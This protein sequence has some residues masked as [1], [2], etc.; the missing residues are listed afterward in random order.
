MATCPVAQRQLA[1]LKQ[2]GTLTACVNAL[3]S[4]AAAN[5]DDNAAAA[6]TKKKKAA[7]KKQKAK[8]KPSPKQKT[9]TDAAPFGAFTALV[10]ME[11]AA[12]TSTPDA[13]RLAAAETENERRMLAL[14]AEAGLSS[15]VFKRAPSD[16]YSWT[17]EQR[18]DFLGLASIHYLCKTV[19]M[20]NT[21]YADQTPDEQTTNS[22]YYSMII[23][24]SSKGEKKHMNNT[25]HAIASAEATRLGVTAPG[26]KKFNM[27]LCPE[28]DSFRLS[29]FAHNGVTPLGMATH[30]PIIVSAPLAELPLGE[31]WLGAGEVDLKVGFNLDQFVS[32]FKP[33]VAKLT[34]HVKDEVDKP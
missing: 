19:I 18:R 34:M 29:G 16:Y 15:A 32:H 22:Q 28:D 11:L 20:I 7:A 5:G 27:R 14:A 30:V 8:H 13:E 26:K 2:I 4:S 31:L 23:Q 9:S 24:Y 21:R 10:P 12:A 6:A 25:V 3:S 33:T 17:L 1:V